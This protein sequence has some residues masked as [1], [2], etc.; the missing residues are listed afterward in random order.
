MGRGQGVE[1]RHPAKL[2]T[3][4]RMVP[5]TENEPVKKASS[6]QGGK[7]CH[8]PMRTHSDGRKRMTLF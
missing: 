1:A 7:P 4:H 5:T 8:R 6:A 2:P 3:G